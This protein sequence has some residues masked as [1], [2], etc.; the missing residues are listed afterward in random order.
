MES[1]IKRSGE[2]RRGV[3]AS[4]GKEKRGMP[5]PELNS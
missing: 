3:C 2:R 1:E 4:D 5:E